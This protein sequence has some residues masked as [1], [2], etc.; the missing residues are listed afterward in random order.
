MGEAGRDR[1]HRDASH[2][3]RELGHVDGP[4]AADARHRLVGTGPQP[5]AKRDGTVMGA[6]R[7]AEHLGRVDLEIRHDAVAL[8][9]PDRDGHPSL[10]RD[11]PVGQQRAEAGDRARPDI[12]D[13]RRGEHPGQQRHELPPG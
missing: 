3:R 6:V 10:G 7:D 2:M 11:P 13:E 12:D 9:W 4:A 8:A 5:L 1:D